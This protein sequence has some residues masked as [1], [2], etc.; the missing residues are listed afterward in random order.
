MRR[1][2]STVLV[3][4]VLM[5]SGTMAWAVCEEK[6]AFDQVRSN[7]QQL[8][9]T[10]LPLS[11]AQNAGLARGLSQLNVLTIFPKLM[12]SNQTIHAPF[13][14]QM[15]AEYAAMLSTAGFN[16]SVLS[17]SNIEKA[18]QI[19][20][21]LCTGVQDGQY[22]SESASRRL[23]F[24]RF[25]F[26]FS[27]PFKGGSGADVRSYFN[28]SLVF[29]SLL[30]LVSLIVI[31]WKTYVLAVPFIENRKHC[32]IPAKLRLEGGDLLG[33]VTILGPQGA[34][35]VSLEA[36]EFDGLSGLVNTQGMIQIALGGRTYRASFDSIMS[37]FCVVKFNSPL[38]RRALT[39]LY[40]R[41]EIVTRFAS[42]SVILSKP[43]T[44]KNTVKRPKPKMQ[45][46][47]A[48]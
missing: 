39:D 27:N 45:K 23:I 31:C 15:I 33:H 19:F 38:E 41:S 28:L 14:K 30:G 16:R 48:L 37:E 22:A 29:F 40:A 36:S 24:E 32:K 11:A 20:E 17:E 21:E 10:G 3:A 43:K 4:L 2:R 26:N 34:R 42:G 6:R 7:T 9:T 35:F 18:V 47:P 13:L 12:A 5:L 1:V 46:A 44:A 25:D 8:L